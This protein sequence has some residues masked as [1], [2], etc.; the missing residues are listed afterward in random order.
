M[1]WQDMRERQNALAIPYISD[2]SDIVTCDCT[3]AW[4]GAHWVIMNGP[5]MCDQTDHEHLWHH[6]DEK[7]KRKIKSSRHVKG[8]NVQA[9]SGVLRS[10]DTHSHTQSIPL[11][12]CVHTHTLTRVRY[13]FWGGGF[14]RCMIHKSTN[15]EPWDPKKQTNSR[16]Q[17]AV[18]MGSKAV[19]DGKLQTTCTNGPEVHWEHKQ[20][21]PLRSDGKDEGDVLRG[22]VR[23]IRKWTRNAIRVA[24]L[25]CFFFLI[26]ARQGVKDTHLRAAEWWKFWWTRLSR[27]IQVE[28]S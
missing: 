22:G 17:G 12:V 21:D 19:A 8:S 14:K 4:R 7:K 16:L 13:V 27:C 28:L 11:I 1:K 23:L 26:S 6:F 3:V 20:S 15:N 10:H 25:L 5:R 2:W 18:V 9:G 24:Y